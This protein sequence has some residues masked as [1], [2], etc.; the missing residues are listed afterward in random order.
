MHRSSAR[1][2]QKGPVNPKTCRLF[3]RRA[4]VVL[5]LIL[6]LPIVLM[7]VMAI[8]EF[9]M[10]FSNEQVVAMASRAGSQV[11]SDLS[12]IPSAGAVPVS[13]E[14]A[15]ARELARIGVTRYRIRLEHNVDF[16]PPP[17]TMAPV[18]LMTTSVGG[19][20][21]GAA[22]FAVTLTPSRRYVRVTVYVRTTDLTPNL[23]S[24]YVVDLSNRVSMQTTLRRHVG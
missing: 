12:V 10:L 8:V 1:E 4:I 17:L 7:L 11:A 9:G 5:E 16:S 2:Q 20:T 24:A 13:V 22:P 15:V 14:T 21:G 6:A 19:P 23:L 3:S 18:V